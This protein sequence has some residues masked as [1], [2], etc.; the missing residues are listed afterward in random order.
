MEP[1][2]RLLWVYAMTVLANISGQNET[3]MTTTGFKTD[4]C[5]NITDLKGVCD[6]SGAWTP[7]QVAQVLLTIRTVSDRLHQQQLQECRGAEPH[8]CPEA[9]VPAN[10]GLVC[11]TVNNRRLCKSLCNQGYDFHFIKRSRPYEECSQATGYRWTSYYVGGNQLAACHN[12]SL[13]VG[14]KP[15]MY[16]Q[17]DCLTAKSSVALQN[18][19]FDDFSADVGAKISGTLTEKC[20]VCG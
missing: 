17:Q 16:F 4:V 2:G 10:G 15:T 12:S 20:L 9:E 14:G 13:Q 1:N 7:Q 5:S 6:S 11:A 8:Q 18:V 3:T 19:V